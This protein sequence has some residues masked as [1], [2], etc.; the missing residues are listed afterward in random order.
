MKLNQM[1]YYYL[2]LTDDEDVVL[3]ALQMYCHNEI[4]WLRIG[5]ESTAGGKLVTDKETN[6]LAS[7]VAAETL[8]LT[9]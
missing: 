3:T 7:P 4:D 9:Q 8:D 2:L 5:M 6:G 1:M